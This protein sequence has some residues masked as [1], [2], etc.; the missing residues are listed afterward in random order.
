MPPAE[1]DV[2]L[3]SQLPP[4]IK[5]TII[6]S[7]SFSRLWRKIMSTDLEFVEKVVLRGTSGRTALGK[8]LL[9]DPSFLQHCRS[10]KTL[11]LP[12]FGPEVLQWAVKK[13]KAWDRFT[14]AAAASAMNQCIEENG[15]PLLAL[16]PVHSAFLETDDVFRNELDDIVTSFGATLS[17]FHAYAETSGKS[18]KQEPYIGQGLESPEMEQLTIVVQRLQLKLDPHLFS[19][20]LGQKLRQLELSDNRDPITLT[21]S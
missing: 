3:K 20:G 15:R 6:D 7:N 9:E 12:A 19:S 11:S 2:E 8:L 1:I 5:P 10:L 18:I 14:T 16:V 4:L 17:V 21:G 13:K